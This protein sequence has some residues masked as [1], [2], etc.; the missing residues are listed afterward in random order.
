MMSTGYT[1]G[2]GGIGWQII[3]VRQ[4]GFGFGITACELLVI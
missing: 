4:P 2:V 3:R 1:C